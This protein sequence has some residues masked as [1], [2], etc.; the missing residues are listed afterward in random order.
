[1]AENTKAVNLTEEEIEAVMALHGATFTDP[2]VSSD[3]KNDALE[4]L[5]YLNKRLKSFDAPELTEV[6]STNTAA[7]WGEAN[8]G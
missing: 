7:G 3:H 5:N 2:T 4:R 6:K 8:N 1:M